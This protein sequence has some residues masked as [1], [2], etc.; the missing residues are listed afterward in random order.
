MKKRRICLLVLC[1]LCLLA[2]S[3]YA[4]SDAEN[5]VYVHDEAG[6]LTQ[7]QAEKLEKMAVSAAA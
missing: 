6:L 7:M 1:T 4:S 2:G 5:G 3:V